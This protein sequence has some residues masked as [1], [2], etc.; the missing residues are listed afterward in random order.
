M[1][2]ASP[3]SKNDLKNDLAPGIPKDALIELGFLPDL[4]PLTAVP[5]RY[6]SMVVFE[7]TGL[8]IVEIHKLFTVLSA[9]CEWHRRCYQDDVCFLFC[10]L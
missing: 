3:N 9:L 6:T 1:E 2:D 5:F 7:Q 4:N 10:V 8:N